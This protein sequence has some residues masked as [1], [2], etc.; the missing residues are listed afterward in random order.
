MQALA[1]GAQ[2]STQ[3]QQGFKN[4]YH[5]GKTVNGEQAFSLF[6]GG[7]RNFQEARWMDTQN[8][9]GSSTLG[10]GFM[11]VTDE[12]GNVLKGD[13]AKAARVTHEGRNYVPDPATGTLR[14]VQTS[15]YLPA[16]RNFQEHQQRLNAIASFCAGG[17][18]VA[19]S[20]F[21]DCFLDACK[22]HTGSNQDVKGR[23]ITESLQRWTAP[24]P[25]SFSYRVKRRNSP[26]GSPS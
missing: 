10:I 14:Y 13:A 6:G 23:I 5:G 9:P 3:P 4:N 24:P 19:Q 15:T 20:V 17:D 12:Q 8:A 18:V 16:I 11:A 2:K 22:P 21:G 7:A 26:S 25:S 1:G